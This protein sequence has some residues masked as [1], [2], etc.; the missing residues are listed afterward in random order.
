MWSHGCAS[1]FQS[2][3]PLDY[4]SLWACQARAMMLTSMDPHRR[5]RVL[6]TMKHEQN[7]AILVAMNHASRKSILEDLEANGD[8]KMTLD[9][10]RYALLMFLVANTRVQGMLQQCSCALAAPI[11]PGRIACRA[12]H[13]FD[14]HMNAGRSVRH[15][16]EMRY[17]FPQMRWTS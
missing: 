5:R 7:A 12:C 8:G 17:H 4:D 13:H 15:G 10:I 2:F 14:E 11:D 6:K 16:P 9:I 3:R 1:K